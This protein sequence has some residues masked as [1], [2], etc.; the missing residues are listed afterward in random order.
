M[1]KFHLNNEGCT[2]RMFDIITEVCI[3]SEFNSD[4]FTMRMFDIITEM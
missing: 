1:S 2:M 4:G 3:V